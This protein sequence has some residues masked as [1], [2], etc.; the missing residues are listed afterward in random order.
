M[1]SSKVFIYVRCLLLF[2]RQTLT[3]YCAEISLVKFTNRLT[4]SLSDLIHLLAA[5]RS[6]CIIGRSL[7]C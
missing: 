3:N 1:A 7:P 5:A 4:K 6:A 2:S